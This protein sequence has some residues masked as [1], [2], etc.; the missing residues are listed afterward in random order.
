MGYQCRSV[1]TAKALHLSTSLFM[2]HDHDVDV[3]HDHDHDHDLHD[4]SKC[5]TSGVASW[6][7]SFGVGKYVLKV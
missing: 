4:R 6:R 1:E 5:A 3:D 7:G 2:S